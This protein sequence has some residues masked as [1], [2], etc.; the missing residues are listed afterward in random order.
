MTDKNVKHTVKTLT[1]WQVSKETHGIKLGFH[2]DG[3]NPIAVTIPISQASAL[4]LTLPRMIKAALRT[5]GDTS[6][7]MAH[8][9]ETWRL[10]YSD[11]PS[12][13]I[14]TLETLEDFDVSFKVSASQMQELGAAAAN[15]DRDAILN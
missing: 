13:L 1:T 3:G 8:P 9:L 15:T 5:W 14:L 10:E 6:S 7:R 12:F 11:D 4:L 2:D